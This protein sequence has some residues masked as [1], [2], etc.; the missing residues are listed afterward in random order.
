M[1]PVPL[2]VPGWGIYS[3]QPN[4]ASPARSPAPVAPHPGGVLGV[5]GLRQCP[6]YQTGEK[7]VFI[8]GH[9]ER[10]DRKRLQCG[11]DCCCTVHAGAFHTQFQVLQVTT[12]VDH[13]QQSM[14][15]DEHALCAVRCALYAVWWHCLRR[16]AVFKIVELCFAAV[17]CIQLGNDT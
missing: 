2:Q 13:S 4:R 6:H 10:I 9:W 8:P 15:L 16:W 5:P 11:E 12:P 14:W 3:Q 1:Q 7:H 17:H